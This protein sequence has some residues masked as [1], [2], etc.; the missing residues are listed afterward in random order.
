MKVAVIIIGIA[1]LGTVSKN[2]GRR[3]GRMGHWMT[4]REH[5]HYRIVEIG[6]NTEMNPGDFRGLAVP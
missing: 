4:N 5:P 6:Q 1:V 2:L 3:V